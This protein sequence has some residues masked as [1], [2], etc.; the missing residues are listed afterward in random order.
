MMV[1]SKS[2]PEIGTKEAVGAYEFTLVPRSMYTTQPR[3]PWCTSWR[4]YHVVQSSVE[5]LARKKSLPSNERKRLSAVHRPRPIDAMAEVQSLD[6]PQQIRNCLHLADHFICRIFEKY[7]DSDEIRLIFD[8]YDIPA[9][10]TQ[11]TFLK[12]QGQLEGPFLLPD[13]PIYAHH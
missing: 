11:A 9:S 8:K 4:G 5:L 2:R 1:I 7:G 3:V 10:L 12:R 13:H 6:K